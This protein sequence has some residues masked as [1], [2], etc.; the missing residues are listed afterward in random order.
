MGTLA[1]G[2]TGA[3]AGGVIGFAIGGPAGALMGAQMGFTAGIIIGSMLFGP[4]KT[5]VEGP[6][7]NDLKI[8]T[9]TYGKT[10]PLIYGTKRIGG[11]VF[12]ATDLIEHRKKKKVGG[13]GKG[14]GAPEQEQITYTYTTSF[15][16]G[17]CEGPVGGI[18][19][20]WA[21]GKLIC[22]LSD[23]GEPITN[24][25]LGDAGDPRNV[26]SSL[27]TSNYQDAEARQ[28]VLPG[29][30]IYL[31][32]Q[33]QQP[34]PA[35]QEDVGVDNTPAYR[36]LC[37][38]VFDDMLL[39]D[40][41][42][43]IPQITVLVSHPPT[44]GAYPFD[45]FDEGIPYDQDY[46]W[47]SD[48]YRRGVVVNTNDEFVHVDL[49][50]HN[51]IKTVPIS[52]SI[53]AWVEINN[54]YIE[55]DEGWA[56]FKGDTESFF[57]G[58][59]TMWIVNIDTGQ[60]MADSGE[61]GRGFF[62]NSTPL[63]RTGS[64]I[65]M[66][67]RVS[68]CTYGC[69]NV[70]VIPPLIP[71]PEVVLPGLSYS[72][73]GTQASFN[74]LGLSF[75]GLDAFKNNFTRTTTGEHYTGH[76][77]GSGFVIT[78]WRNSVNPVFQVTLGAG[79][80]NGDGRS[81]LY[82]AVEDGFVISEGDI[83]YKFLFNADGTAL[84]QDSR[85]FDGGPLLSGTPGPWLQITMPFAGQII[86][87]QTIGANFGRFD[88]INMIDYDPG[89]THTDWVTGISGIPDTPI[90]NPVD[91]SL[92]LQYGTGTN[93]AFLYL[94]RNASS[95]ETLQEV[96]EDISQRVGLT[97]AD[98]DASELAGDNV[99]G[100]SISSQ[101]AAKAVLGAAMQ[102]YFFDMVESDY[103]LKF[104]KRGSAA[105]K[106]IPEIDLGAGAVGA[107]NSVKITE[108]RDQEWENFPAVISFS[109]A[110]TDND[111]LTNTQV[112]RRAAEAV[113]SRQHV[114]LETPF[115]FPN[116]E[117][118]NIVERL[119]SELWFQR[120]RYET[121]LTWEHIDLD[122]A[123]VVNIEFDGTT[124]S[125]IIMDIGIGADG[126][127]DMGF[128]SENIN[129]YTRTATSE[130]QSGVPQ[131]TVSLPSAS[132]AIVADMQPLRDSD[133]DAKEYYI[134]GSRMSG[135]TY[136]GTHVFDSADNETW[137]SLAII[138][139]SEEAVVGFATN[140]LAEPA[141]HTLIDHTNTVNVKLTSGTLASSSESVV[142]DG[143]TN[144]LIIE[145]SGSGGWEIIQFITAT[146]ESDG[147]YT[148]SGLLRGRRGSENYMA[149]HSPGDRVWLPEIDTT[150]T[151]GYG[152][153]E[154]G[155]VRY[156][157]SV[158]LGQNVYD[159]GVL[160]NGTLYSRRQRLLAPSVDQSYTDTNGDI[161][162]RWRRRS[163]KGDFYPTVYFGQQ[164]GDA[165]SYDYEVD[166]INS[167]ATVARTVT[168]TASANGSVITL[169]SPAYT[170]NVTCKYELADITADGFDGNTAIVYQ[171]NTGL[172][173]NGGRG[174]PRTVIIDEDS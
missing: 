153:A 43:R 39:T 171:L 6:R 1:L 65:Y 67:G 105:V 83:F 78:G 9:S 130:D 108:T 82:E 148:L 140:A 116:D 52:P 20:I 161:N 50:G 26:W 168:T 28:I 93:K 133:A 21:D 96:I 64:E 85:T 4:G 22:N 48:D 138:I 63:W 23:D 68:G 115:V 167:D 42:N 174:E 163:R 17:L 164:I 118:R 36:G 66:L 106:T 5:Q 10:I 94:D 159:S 11:N 166:F 58:L 95:S 103:I 134:A 27:A 12:W 25:V 13:G 127:L 24:S 92:Q 158:N 2:I 128:V 154:I 139:P 104:P 80:I 19:K 136:I 15:A 112:W 46:M 135:T 101:A 84:T 76:V 87:K 110:D 55:V 47:F 131:Q 155:T 49:V 143:V 32:T 157:K 16:L 123:D 173:Y 51:I 122:P 41:G 57:N 142:L 37:Y 125:A 86:Y 81:G 8:T 120:T 117:A 74:L 69:V 33:T 77:D 100:L 53:T 121:S 150:V 45:S 145:D 34:D 71:D 29:L 31:G 18:L 170:G 160:Y 113:Y 165:P 172:S 109:Y 132:F 73:P 40:F 44:S 156:I 141:S 119:G 56:L 124:V 151:G 60:V 169:P 90:Y 35:I 97:L 59:I 149:N 126:K 88:I 162:L 144:I 70:S 3:V 75:G 114:H 61:I 147:S 38:I 99:Y 14:G 62:G 137:S 54:Y 30:R 79:T 89:F 102:P 91:H 111:D 72:H 152:D 129:V 146:L 107:S 7:L 98:I